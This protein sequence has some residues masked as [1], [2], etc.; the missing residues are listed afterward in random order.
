MEKFQS[1]VWYL[2]LAREKDFNWNGEYRFY[3]YAILS[4]SY[5]DQIAS[6]F[7]WDELDIPFT[8]IAYFENLP[9]SVKLYASSGYET[10]MNENGTVNFVLDKTSKKLYFNVSKNY[11]YPNDEYISRMD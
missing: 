6:N 1:C 11:L 8:G 3:G 9:D 10:A 4:P 5:Y 2:D 7:V